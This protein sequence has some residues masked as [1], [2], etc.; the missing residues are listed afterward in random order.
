MSPVKCCTDLKVVC[1][2]DVRTMTMSG[3]R[4]AEH[5]SIL[6]W[7]QESKSV[8]SFKAFC[9]FLLFSDVR[10]LSLDSA[11]GHGSDGIPW[12]DEH[13]FAPCCFSGRSDSYFC[14]W[15]GAPVRL[16]IVAYVQIGLCSNISIIYP[17]TYIY[18]YPVY[19]RYICNYICMKLHPKRV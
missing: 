2:C 15:P 11:Q 19:V 10:M 17:Y 18:I 1:S 8:N 6:F 16:L 3:H 5:C 9:I 7:S 12:W 13:L 4:L 14:L